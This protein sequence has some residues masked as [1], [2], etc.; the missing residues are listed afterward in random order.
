MI[1]SRISITLAFILFFALCQAQDQKGVPEWFTKDM[2]KLVGTWVTSNAEYQSENEPFDEYGL[3]WKW[4]IGKSSM[5]GRLYGLKNGEEQGTFWEFRQ[6][7]DF[8]TDKAMLVQYGWNGTIGSGNVE[9][10][11]DGKTKIGQ[12]FTTPDGVSSNTGHKAHFENEK[13]VTASF[14]IDE[15]GN[16]TKDR[17]YTWERKKES[18]KSDL[19]VFSM[20]LAVNDIKASKDFYEKL[21]FKPL[22]GAGGIEQN[23]LILMKDNIKLGLFRGMFPSNTLTFNPTNGRAIYKLAKEAGLNTITLSGMD[24]E[25]GPCSF[26]I[27]DP[28]GNSILFDQH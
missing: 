13:H 4:A 3:E 20:S 9:H 7:W 27:I 8:A 1:K 2:E 11:G 18:P 12:V 26:S 14:N 6:Y 21:G 25:S 17:S 16:W 24:K 23:W 28:D 5:T 19:G 22:E 10:E 15:K